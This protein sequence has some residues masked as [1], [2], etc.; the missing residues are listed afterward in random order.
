[1]S[2]VTGSGVPVRCVG[3]V[4]TGAMGGGVVQSLVRAGVPTCARDIRAEAQDAA[5]KHGATPCASPAAVA[6]ACDAMIL[7]VVDADQIETVLFGTD[8]A[9]QALAPGAIVVLSS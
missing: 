3:V 9:A 2:P 8:G 1:M 6:C 4:G 5:V 7:L